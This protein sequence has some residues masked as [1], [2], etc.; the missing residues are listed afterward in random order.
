MASPGGIAL[1]QRSSRIGGEPALWAEDVRRHLDAIDAI[2]ALLAEPTSLFGRGGCGLSVAQA[3]RRFD[4]YGR[5]LAAWPA[6]HARAARANGAA[7]A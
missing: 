2:D 6:L 5:L 1:G 7:P 3:M 4:R